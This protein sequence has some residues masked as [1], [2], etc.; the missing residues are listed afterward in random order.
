MRKRLWP[1]ILATLAL[2][3]SALIRPNGLPSAAAAGGTT[4]DFS[5]A[6]YGDPGN[7]DPARADRP[8]EWAVT[9]NVFQPLLNVNAVGQLLPGLARTV[10]VNKHVVAITLA[11]TTTASGQ[12]VTATMVARALAR[13]LWPVVNSSVAH[14]ILGSVRGA[15][16]VISGRTKLL[17]GIRIT[18]HR[19]L[20][21]QLTGSN[22]TAF[23]HNLAN[24]ALS[25]VPVSDQIQ[26]GQNWQFANLDGTGGWKLTRWTPGDHLLFTWAGRPL[27]AGAPTEVNLVEYPKPR[28]ALLSVVNGVVDA[29]PVSPLAVH[30][31]QAGWLADLRVFSGP[32]AVS[33]YYRRGA[34]RVSAYR[35]LPIT[36][37]V[38]DTFGAKPHA[39][40]RRWPRRMLNHRPMTIWV[41]ASNLVAVALARTLSA[42]EPLVSVRLTTA[43]RL[44]RLAA[45]GAIDAYIGTYSRFASSLTVPLMRPSVF[46][47][48]S[49]RVKTSTVFPNGQLKWSSVRLKG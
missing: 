42:H 5:L 41:N 44:T 14:R 49:P 38:A 28:E 8:P 19:S 21:I 30:T 33:L 1:W 31:L 4:G 25:I 24:P 17:S 40:S 12:P 29:A 23:L 6:I 32:G 18:G 39:L 27:G 37:W 3:I 36:R 43:G 26:G 46:W 45:R 15:Q 22:V 48:E 13:P 9:D 2:M 11:R 7:L 34:L 35:P 16:A 47:L 10:T 20:S